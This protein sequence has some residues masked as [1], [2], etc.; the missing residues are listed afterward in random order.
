MMRAVDRIICAALGATCI[1]AACGS[2]RVV[3]PEC[4]LLA[5]KDSVF[6][7]V[8]GHE[9]VLAKAQCSGGARSMLTWSSVDPSTASVDAN[10]G[11]IAAL[12]PGATTIHATVVDLPAV[13][14]PIVVVVSCP[15]LPA[16]G[17]SVT[18]SAVQLTPNTS[19]TIRAS[20]TRYSDLARCETIVDSAFTFTSS[21]TVIAVVDASGRVT[22]RLAGQTVVRAT[23]VANSN[24]TA[25]VPVTVAATPP[26]VRIDFPV[27]QVALPSWGTATI[28]PNVHLDPGAPAGTSRAVTYS[29]TNPC[30]A[31]VSPDGTL[32]GGGPGLATITATAVA[33]PNAVATL[34]VTV[35]FVRGPLLL[36]FRSF[37]AGSPPTAVD[38]LAMRGVVD[39]TLNV[40]REALTRPARL[41]VTLAGQPVLTTMIPVAAGSF[42]PYP[43]SFRIDTDARDANGQRRFANGSQLLSATVS[44]GPPAS[45]FPD[46]PVPTVDFTQGATVNQQVTL[47]NP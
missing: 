33:N 3:A 27:S 18:P 38:I 37:V 30:T 40:G 4:S 17:A 39:V 41:D 11:V 47:A 36:T 2:D 23:L 19:A 7:S 8:G 24:I 29:T 44:W 32:L 35:G 34:P 6:L 12:K 20:I 28:A 46:C 31:R 25:S 22:G 14:V 16:I 1:I 21:D 42:E 10:S 26:V 5:A 45:P 9:N 13:S 15:G 43:F